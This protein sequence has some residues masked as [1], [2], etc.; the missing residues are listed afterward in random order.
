MADLTRDA[1]IDAATQA[2]QDADGACA[3]DDY[4]EFYRTVAA[5]VVAASFPLIAG[6]IEAEAV[7]E[8][9]LLPPRWPGDRYWD[10]VTAGKQRAAVIVRSLM[11]DDGE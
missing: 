5:A 1:L 8:A 2:V 4:Q 9:D 11:G 10:G 3:P 6:A 7:Q